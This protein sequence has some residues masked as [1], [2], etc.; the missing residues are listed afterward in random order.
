MNDK[1]ITSA[2]TALLAGKRARDASR[3]TGVACK[4]IHRPGSLLAFCWDA[5]YRGSRRQAKRLIAD[6]RALPGEPLFK[7]DEQA[8]R[9][10]DAVF[11]PVEPEGAVIGPETKR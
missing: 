1:L 8:Q 3:Y 2:S 10:M 9:A 6:F 5:G 7:T 4:N 11:G